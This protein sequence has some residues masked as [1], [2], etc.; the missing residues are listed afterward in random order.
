MTQITTY[1]A[2][3]L[4]GEEIFLKF[5]KLDEI[6]IC[7]EDNSLDVPPHGL[8][9]IKKIGR[10]VERARR[11]VRASAAAKIIFSL[12][13]FCFIILLFHTHVILLYDVI[14]YKRVRAH[15]FKAQVNARAHTQLIIR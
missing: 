1:K 4:N 11:P 12:F 15:L 6:V 5:Y 14:T 7:S 9:I 3:C 2:T 13:F 10:F 8:T